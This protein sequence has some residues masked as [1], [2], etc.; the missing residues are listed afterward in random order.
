MPQKAREK[1]KTE[2]NVFDNFTN[3]T[4]F[5]LISEGHFEGL[6]STISMGKE[7]NIFSAKRKDGSRVMIKIYR[8]EACDFNRMYDYIKEDPRYA[9]IRGKKRKIIFIP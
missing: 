6:E 7:A 2:H 3:R 8:L 1:F 9:D 4:L 5:K